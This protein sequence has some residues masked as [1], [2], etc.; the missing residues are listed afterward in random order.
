MTLNAVCVCVCC[1][2]Q[3]RRRIIC[4]SISADSGKSTK[5]WRHA[6]LLFLSHVFNLAQ[7]SVWSSSTLESLFWEIISLWKSNASDEQQSEQ[8]CVLQTPALSSVWYSVTRGASPWACCCLFVCRLKDL[9][10]AMDRNIVIHINLLNNH[11]HSH[12]SE[13]K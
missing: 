2:T 9:L 5:I 13:K 7:R 1:W 3:L 12:T 8:R 6:C 4:Q 11:R 10:V